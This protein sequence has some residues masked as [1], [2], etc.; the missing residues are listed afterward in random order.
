MSTIAAWLLSI[1][2]QGAALLLV[3]WL[4]DRAFPVLRGAWRELLWRTALFGGMVT[5]TLQLGSGQLPLA[6]HWQLSAPAST[7]STPLGQAPRAPDAG[8]T[9]SVA[10][11]RSSAPRNVGIAPQAGPAWTASM[12]TLTQI[13]LSAPG[14][15]VFAWLA[16]A[17]L[18]SA[19]TARNF[20]R[21]RRALARA[22]A[23]VSPELQEELA[24]LARRAGVAPPQ[25]LVL[26]GIPSPIAAH[27]A[28]IVLPAWAIAT[29]DD[30][31]LRAMLAHELAHVMRRDPQW[32]LML[33]AWRALFW[34]VP[35]NVVALRR[36]DEIAE[37]ACDAHA[38]Q[39]P[40]NAHGLAECLAVCAEHHA[41]R[42]DFSLAPAMAARRSALVFRIE[43]LLEGVSMETT[44]SGVS[45][46]IVALAVLVACSAGL[47]SI[48]IDG[49][50]AHA[51]QSQAAPAAKADN[52][53][54]SSISIHSD[55]DGGRASMT[56]SM[57]DDTHQFRAN[58]TGK[59]DFN[60]DETDI[61]S[62][63]PGGTA[64]LEET[65]AGVTQRIEVAARGNDLERRY[66]IDDAEHPFD[67]KARALMQ[68]AVKELV[69]T[70][71][72]AEA[73]VKRL[74]ARGGASGVLDEIEQ[75]HSDYVRGVYLGVL[76]GMG[77][78]T[79]EQLDRSIDL[80][81]AM[82]V[83]Y[84]RR[85]ALTAL[86]DKQ[87]LD[88]ARQATFLRQLAHFDSDYERAELLTGVVGR[89]ADTDAVRQ[90]WLD[91]ALGVQSDYERRRTLQSMLEHGGLDDA[92]LGSV[93]EASASMSS[94]YEHREL[95]VAAARRVHNIDAVAVAYTRSAQGIHS[96]YEHR[97][98]LLALINAGKLGAH[99]AD[100]VLDSAA[101]ITSG[102]E[103]REVLVALAHVMPQDSALI[104]H[105]RAV[106]TRLPE[107]ERGEAERALAH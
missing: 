96:D 26:E 52:R 67:D 101:L 7:A 48:G 20:M 73:R 64:R 19:R 93:I 31:Q 89:L 65:R 62:L 81:G 2:V 10:P 58:V 103:C 33:A 59:I 43:R 98:A 35:L 66:F 29:L 3:A 28:R 8:A 53:S 92:Q 70:G 90:A 49:G 50:V 71:V 94:D 77:K 46:R 106:A 25:L 24:L 72:N 104:A 78:F 99:G 100:A 84:E 21:L 88:A 9:R 41:Q 105:Y 80:A 95:L 97:E 86:F 44:T 5:A 27:G 16:V 30:A 42:H 1:A 91:A 12:Y 18:A 75:I 87:S 107:Y 45:G 22:D 55:D 6:G 36:L 17:L 76:V 85:Q 63:G 83:D 15:I 57:S 74:Y 11:A 102:Y 82:Q 34:F 60:D 79:P 40:G 54:H 68:V 61:V 37:L 56:V 13:T 4:I 51:A 32:K 69:R 14:W 39:Y 38:A 47:P 23:V